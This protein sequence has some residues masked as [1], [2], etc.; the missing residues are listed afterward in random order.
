MDELNESPFGAIFWYSAND[1]RQDR[2][3]LLRLSRDTGGNQR[4]RQSFLDDRV[5]TRMGPKIPE[6]IHFMKVDQNKENATLLWQSSKTA[7]PSVIKEPRMGYCFLFVAFFNVLMFANVLFSVFHSQPL[8]W[9]PLLMSPCRGH[10]DCLLL[11]KNRNTHM[12]KQLQV[13]K[14]ACLFVSPPVNLQCF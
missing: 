14:S 3:W 5:K 4:H 6:L 1:V 12:E 13:F 9:F 7:Q 8:N 10:S 2:K 11:C